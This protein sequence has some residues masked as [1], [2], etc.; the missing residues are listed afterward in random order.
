MKEEFILLISGIVVC[1]SIL[2][3][4]N[5]KTK[6]NLLKDNTITKSNSIAIMIKEDGDTDYSKFSKNSIPKGDYALN[7]EKSYCE[8]NGNV[9]EYDS[10][11]GKVSISILGSDKCYLYFDYVDY[12]AK[13][14][15]LNANGGSVNIKKTLSQSMLSKFDDLGLSYYFFDQSA[16][17]YVKFGKYSSDADIYYSMVE[18][19][20][21][22]SECL[23]E[24]NTSKCNTKRLGTAGSNMLW[25]IIRING[26]GS[27]RMVYVGTDND[28]D[29]KNIG[30]KRF[31]NLSDCSTSNKCL[32]YMYSS[33][34]D[35]NANNTSSRVKEYLDSWY[36]TYIKGGQNN[37]Y[38]YSQYIA[39]A[40]Y[41]NDRNL[42]NSEDTPQQDVL[43]TADMTMYAFQGRLAMLGYSFNCYNKYN[44][45][46][47]N[48]YIDNYEGTGTLRFPIGLITADEVKLTNN[49][50]VLMTMTPF[51]MY[52]GGNPVLAFDVHTA[53][54]SAV[55][56]V[57]SL[58]KDVTLLGTGTKSDPY[59]IEGLNN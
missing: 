5:T 17:N 50:S 33:T 41:C 20:I 32:G 58:S 56:P 28:N 31:N 44:S 29:L 9:V 39:D 8:N 54:P 27:I 59:Y 7:K 2:F 38:P 18:T 1:L 43:D 42:A 34:D 12:P 19:Y 55:Y 3:Y 16:N 15:I 11:N 53:S 52:N 37:K 6:N 40:I 10:A 30:S 23:S 26:D 21:G 49:T 51:A 46:T 45:F 48:K 57:I 4:F 25:R 35:G 13:R 24:E 14:L 36:F 47:V 22:E